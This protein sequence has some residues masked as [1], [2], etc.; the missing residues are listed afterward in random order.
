MSSVR[1]VPAR[2][3]ALFFACAFLALGLCASA[4]RVAQQP[5]TVDDVISNLVARNSALTTFHARI[6]IRLHTGIPFLN[7]ALEGDT[8]FKRPDRYEV[9]LT[10]YPSWAKGFEQLYSD[11]GD[12]AVWYKKFSY[13]LHGT[14]TYQGHEDL[15]LRL[16]ERVRGSLDHE[17]VL[18]D[19][20][21]WVIDEM[22]YAYYSGGHITVQQTYR[23]N[24]NYMLL[25]T[26]HAV[27]AMPPFP[28]ARA[29]SK[30]SDYQLNVAID[31]AVFTK[32]QT[33]HIGVH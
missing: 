17:D 31:D 6:T 11:I 7:P 20:Q 12:P 21:R 18:V 24:G 9:V 15:V 2:V 22:D 10:K 23:E 8:Y 28:R 25:D 26:Q 29:D 13:T 3:A 14:R 5:L 32:E 19:P 33:Q 4:K 1:S 27:I 30:Y 16:I